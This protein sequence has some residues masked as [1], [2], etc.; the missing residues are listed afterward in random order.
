MQAC[1]M[2]ALVHY[3]PSHHTQAAY[4]ATAHYTTS[5]YHRAQLDTPSHLEATTSPRATT[6]LNRDRTWPKPTCPKTSQAALTHSSHPR[7]GALALKA[8]L[9]Q[10]P[11]RAPLASSPPRAD[12]TTHGNVP[13]YIGLHTHADACMHACAPVWHA[14]VLL[15]GG[16]EGNNKP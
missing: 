4:R 2:Q 8:C 1:N 7:C 6:R 11:R 14:C 9:R 10:R 3:N 5:S 16:L 15:A 13:A 12:S